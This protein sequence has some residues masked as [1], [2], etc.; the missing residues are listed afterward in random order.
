MKKALIIFMLIGTSFLLASCLNQS[1]SPAAVNSSSNNDSAVFGQMKVI[2]VISKNFS[3][4]PTEIK[5]NRGD[6]IKIIL[7][8]QEGF[9]D[10]KIDEF[11]AATNKINT[12]EQSTVE[13][14]A[15]RVGTFEYYC[16]V[17]THRQM[18]MVGK[19]IVE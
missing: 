12:G 7:T 3:F 17:G 18:G 10:W 15:D 6:K 4:L 9:H 8:S 14:I 5:V 1:N 19:L 11:N 2:N 16:S 13:F